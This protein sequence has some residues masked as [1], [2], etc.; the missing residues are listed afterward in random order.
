M[1]GS[2]MISTVAL[3]AGENG[4]RYRAE[5]GWQ[6]TRNEGHSRGLGRVRKRF[7]QRERSRDCGLRISR[8]TMVGIKPVFR[9][10]HIV[11]LHVCCRNLEARRL[12]KDASS[13]QEL[14]AQQELPSVSWRTQRLLRRQRGGNSAR[15]RA[16]WRRMQGLVELA[17]HLQNPACLQCVPKCCVL[18]IFC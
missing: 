16:R 11:W 9:V 2:G 6:L 3:V 17:A 14:Q 10:L 12:F 5:A 13:T 15:K 18:G 1:L 7:L 8:A 4:G